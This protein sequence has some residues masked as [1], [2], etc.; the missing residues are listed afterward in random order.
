MQKV[1]L[2]IFTPA[3]ALALVLLFSEGRTNDNQ[4]P[5]GNANDPP[6][7]GSCA[8]SGCHSDNPV[9]TGS[10]AISLTIGPDAASQNPLSSFNYVP[11]TTYTMVFDI[12]NSTGGSYGFQM[13]G[14]D[15]T[16]AQAGTFAVVNSANTSLLTLGSSGKSYI[17]HKNAST[18]K[19]WTF[20][21]TAPSSN[22]GDIS[23]YAI[24]NVANGNGN[25]TGDIIHTATLVLSPASSTGIES[26]GSLPLGLS[27]N[28]ASGI[29]RLSF[30]GKGEGET[31]VSLTEISGRKLA[32]LYRGSSEAGQRDLLVELP[33]GLAHGMYIVSVKDGSRMAHSRVISK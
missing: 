22:V 17:G 11:G 10:Q 3:A 29:V 26:P 9:Q 5:P 12:V 15:N 32:E 14:L 1:F 13:I 20:N 4:P 21:W 6:S 33:S 28:P 8:K 19:S 16:N 25:R 23:F 7:N 30:E 27:P 31:V 2:R 18:V 24:A